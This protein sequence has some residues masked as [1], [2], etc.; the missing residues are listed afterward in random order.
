MGV[1][2]LHFILFKTTSMKSIAIQLSSID[3]QVLYKDKIVKMEEVVRYLQI[4]NSGG[5]LL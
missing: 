2:S 5:Y 3:T 1:R 4:A